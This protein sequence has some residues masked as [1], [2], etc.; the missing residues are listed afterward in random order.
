MAKKISKGQIIIV[1]IALFLIIRATSPGFLFAVPAPTETFSTPMNIPDGDISWQLNP[2][3]IQ[4]DGFILSYDPH[5]WSFPSIVNGQCLDFSPDGKYCDADNIGLKDVTVSHWEPPGGELPICPS[6][7]CSGISQGT[8]PASCLTELGGSWDSAPAFFFCS[9]VPQTAGNWQEF[10][11]FPLTSDG[12]YAGTANSGITLWSES[13]T[14]TS[15][16]ELPPPEKLAGIQSVSLQLSGAN[17][18]ATRGFMGYGYADKHVKVF[19][20]G[21]D[22]GL[23]TLKLPETGT[24]SILGL[25]SIQ[26]IPEPPV[27]Y[28]FVDLPLDRDYSGEHTFE[29][30]PY[31][32]PECTKAWHKNT[33]YGG[34]T[35]GYRE[36]TNVCDL[37]EFHVEERQSAVLIINA[38]VYPDEE[39][40][41]CDFLNPCSEDESCISGTCVLT[42]DITLDMLSCDTTDGTWNFDTESCECPAD[43][44]WTESF[45]CVL[46][47]EISEEEITQLSEEERTELGILE[48]PTVPT[49]PT[50]PMLEGV[51]E[52]E[53]FE[54]P[55]G[56]VAIILLILG[57]FYFLV[58]K[59]R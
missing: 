30:V 14:F 9:S 21:E 27:P 51:D 1:L 2:E 36:I 45:G 46:P 23:Y 11:T 28:V 3:T 59:K 44:S 53:R 8:E 32:T 37:K 25:M 42:D 48:E 56:M 10:N 33:L 5:I 35:E 54:I 31:I 15:N 29:I 58:L 39:V 40:P 52:D 26:V 34:A 49:L 7:S 22:L 20:D 38:Y 4:A 43:S 16:V 55:W 17:I 57:A 47:E 41:Q 18:T 50:E 6:W 24:Q 13:A 19:M 12:Q